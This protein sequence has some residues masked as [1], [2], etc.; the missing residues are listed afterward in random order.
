MLKQESTGVRVLKNAI[1]KRMDRR[2]RRMRLER[3]VK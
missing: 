3:I 2:I 1:M